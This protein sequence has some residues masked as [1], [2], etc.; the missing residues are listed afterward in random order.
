MA[1]IPLKNY[2]IERLPLP[3]IHAIATPLMSLRWT[4]RSAVGV[5]AMSEESTTHHRSYV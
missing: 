2:V 5:K 3:F 4:W 1:Q